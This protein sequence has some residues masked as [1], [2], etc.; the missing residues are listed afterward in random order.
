[1]LL[2]GN[3]RLQVQLLPSVNP[4]SFYVRLS[5][6][7]EL[8]SSTAT[9]SKAEFRDM[10]DKIDLLE[11]DSANGQSL[12]VQNY[13]LTPIGLLVAVMRLLK[14]GQNDAVI[15]KAVTRALAFI[16]SWNPRLQKRQVLEVFDCAYGLAYY[17]GRK[18]NDLVEDPCA[19]CGEKDFKWNFLGC[20]KE[21]SDRCI[22]FCHIGPK[23]CYNGLGHVEDQVLYLI[24]VSQDFTCHECSIHDF[25]TGSVQPSKNAATS[26]SQ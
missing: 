8:F 9:Y 3:L 22:Q 1:M 5:D 23:G 21:S 14:E 16:H 18:E 7:F 6:V 20:S 10:Q 24:D 19:W 2:G 12:F 17:D 4:C 13:L 25:N 15:V 11:D 26:P